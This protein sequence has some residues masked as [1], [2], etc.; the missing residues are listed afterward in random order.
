MHAFIQIFG[1]AD[2]P[3][4]PAFQRK[5]KRTSVSQMLSEAHV[6]TPLKSTAN[7]VSLSLLRKPPSG[8]FYSVCV[9][10][11][12]FARE[13]SVS[14]ATGLSALHARV[15]LYYSTKRQ[16]EKATC[17][18]VVGLTFVNLKSNA[19]IYTGPML[20]FVATAMLCATID[21]ENFADTRGTSKWAT[22]SGSALMDC[23]RLWLGT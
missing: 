19:T 20:V 6:T 5:S 1:C 22:L 12:L 7:K 15:Y 17:W 16:R 3:L 13:R 10:V 9:C 18:V 21:C 23:S 11:S 8:V 2:W 4:W 14:H